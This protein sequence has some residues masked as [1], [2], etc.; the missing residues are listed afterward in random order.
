MKH[1]R[2]KA[3]DLIDS[4]ADGWFERKDIEK[5][6][7]IQ[8]NDKFADVSIE[9]SRL[10]KLIGMPPKEMAEHVLENT[11][12]PEIFES[13]EAFVGEKTNFLNLKLNKT[14]FISRTLNEILDYGESY[15]RNDIG[16]E[17]LALFDYSSP[18]VGKP[19]HVGHIR[20]TILGDSLIKILQFSGYKT[21]GINYLGDVGL[22]IGK[23]LHEFKE[24]GSIERLQENPEGELLD[25]YVGFCKKEAEIDGNL[26]E[27]YGEEEERPD[28][29]MTQLAKEQIKLVEAEEPETIA[30]LKEIQ[31]YSLKSFD[32]VY[33]LLSVT[34]DETTGQ[35][36]F[37]EKGKELVMK[38]HDDG[39]ITKTEDGALRIL[40]R[41]WID[42]NVIPLTEI[43]MLWVMHREH[44]SNNFSPP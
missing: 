14:L 3:I 37:S 17:R 30:L 16:Q 9:M 36:H 25:L 40:E 15:G 13:A 34:I 4:Y 8:Q 24:R 6:T 21:H 18:N 26:E 22:H 44:I 1:A 11:T 32:R 7:R 10:E 28:N 19:L 23:V 31:T 33:D 12:I 2:E 35:S 5:V 43:F 20:S 29:W 42:L 41:Q 27:T 38:A 39:I